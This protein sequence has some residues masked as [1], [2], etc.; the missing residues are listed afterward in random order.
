MARKKDLSLPVETKEPVVVA[1]RTNI[2]EGAKE[3]RKLEIPANVQEPITY[4]HD[5]IPCEDG[6]KDWDHKKTIYSV[7]HRSFILWCN[8][9]Q[10]YYVIPAGSVKSIEVPAGAVPK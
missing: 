2:L 4:A 3:T 6:H 8:S 7:D 5:A 9:C 10:G 1:R